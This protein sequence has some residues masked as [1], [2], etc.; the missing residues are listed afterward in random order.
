MLF[1]LLG[2]MKYGRFLKLPET[3][4]GLYEYVCYWRM[5][6]INV[7]LALRGGLLSPKFHVTFKANNTL[8]LCTD[9]FVFAQIG[10]NN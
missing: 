1:K 4:S 8:L 9:N 2:A 10:T 6:A 7:R 3:Q 5:L